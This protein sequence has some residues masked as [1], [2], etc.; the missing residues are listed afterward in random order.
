MERYGTLIV[1]GTGQCIV[2]SYR[3]LFVNHGYKKIASCEVDHYIQN[4]L[5]HVQSCCSNA[6]L[7][8]IIVN[9]NH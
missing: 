6:C 9:V 1:N 5:L 7:E 4:I 3:I 2:V 8:N